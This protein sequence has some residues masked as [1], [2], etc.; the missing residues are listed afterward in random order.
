MQLIRTQLMYS[1]QYGYL[2]IILMYKYDKFVY[3]K[4]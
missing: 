1:I 3:L 2:F 4:K